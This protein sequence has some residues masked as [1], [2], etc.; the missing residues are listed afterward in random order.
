MAMLHARLVKLQQIPTHHDH[1]L[2]FKLLLELQGHIGFMANS[3]LLIWL[4]MKE[5]LT[6]HLQ[7]GK[8]VRHFTNTVLKIKK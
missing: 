1:M 8:Q 6:H 3:L 4:A 5:E 7:I 2:C